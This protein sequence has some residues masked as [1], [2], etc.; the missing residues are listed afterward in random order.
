M[1]PTFLSLTF[2]EIWEYAL[3]PHLIYF[4]HGR[5]GDTNKLIH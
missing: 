1:G 5:M 2:T 3:L 4:R